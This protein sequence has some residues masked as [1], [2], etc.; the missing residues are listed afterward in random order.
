MIARTQRKRLLFISPVVPGETGNGLAMR[1]GLFLDA[2][3]RHFDVDLAIVPVAARHVAMSDFVTRRCARI[4]VIEPQIGTH[5]RLLSGL[6]DPKARCDAFRQFGQP[7]LAAG[8]TDP[9]IAELR[10]WIGTNGYAV[11][12]ASR[13]Y[14]AGLAAAVRVPADAARLVLDCDEDDIAT[15]RSIGAMHRR[16]GNAFRSEWALLE[17][18]AFARLARQALAG[19][20]VVFMA[21]RR[22]AVRLA[23][24][25]GY[26]RFVV[27]PNVVAMPARRARSARS[28]A[29]TVLFVGTLGYEPNEDAVQWFVSRV[30]HRLSAAGPGRVRLV[31]VGTG[32][33]ARLQRLSGRY[34]ITVTG[35]VPEVESLYRSADVV[36]AP[37]RAGGGTRIK[38]LEAAAYGVPAVAT[39]I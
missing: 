27:V 32:P 30:W 17:A 39:R 4:A 21:S 33:S 13:L 18:E 16:N 26:G 3:A 20:D 2:Y 9:V 8:I 24:E 22:D 25:T 23:Q 34:G 38:L 12:H 11:V 29:R 36:I 35:P 31:I 37:L 5:F 6:H 15:Q 7:S 1:T 14:L 10:S 28:D 19:F